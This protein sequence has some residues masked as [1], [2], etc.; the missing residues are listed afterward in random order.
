MELTVNLPLSAYEV[1]A[2]RVVKVS[3]SD[4][5]STA[6]LAV[7][8]PEKDQGKNL[9]ITIWG[10]QVE[11]KWDWSQGW[12]YAIGVRFFGDGSLELHYV[13]DLVSGKDMFLRQI[14]LKEYL[15]TLPEP[16]IY[17]PDPFGIAARD[18]IRD[19]AA[20]IEKAIEPIKPSRNLVESL[21]AGETPKELWRARGAELDEQLVEAA[22]KGDLVA[23][24]MAVGKGADVN[25]KV[26]TMGSYMAFL[27]EFETPLMAAVQSYYARTG[28]N[29]EVVRYL[30]GKGADPALEREIQ[31]DVGISDVKLEGTGKYESAIDLAVEGE[32]KEYLK[33]E[34]IKR[35]RTSSGQERSDYIRYC[36]HVREKWLLKGLDAL[37]DDKQGERRKNSLILTPVDIRDPAAELLRVCD[38]AVNLIA[39]ISRATFAFPVNE[40]TNYSDAQLAEV[41]AFLKSL[42]P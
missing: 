24:V 25:A 6:S 9:V 38:I 7:V 4:Q 1:Y 34:F 30:V 15:T 28:S 35:L 41:R 10:R 8:Y 36:E 22:R 11:Y 20:Q 23:V 27:V 3:R 29:M 40:W 37:L 12:V 2:G 13:K 21:E 26:S 32:V 18:R 16:F 33:V 17:F 31:E 5:E 39:S 14:N 42:E 19:Q